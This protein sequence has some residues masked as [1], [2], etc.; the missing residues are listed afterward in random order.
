MTTVGI[1]R[2]KNGSMMKKRNK[3][4]ATVNMARMNTKES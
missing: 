3:K 2:T 4:T 1:E